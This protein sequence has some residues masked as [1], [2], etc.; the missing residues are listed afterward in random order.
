MGRRVHE[1]QLHRH[2]RRVTQDVVVAAD[3]PD[4]RRV[5]GRMSVVAAVDLRRGAPVDQPHQVEGHDVGEC[6]HVAAHHTLHAQVHRDRGGG[7]QHDQ[8][9][10][11]DRDD[12]P[13]LAVGWR[14]PA[15]QL[16]LATAS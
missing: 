1:G 5:Q 15:H 14:V 16:V 2:L 9:H 12:R 7:D 3:A 6:L 13:P 10:R 8:E 4:E 11:H